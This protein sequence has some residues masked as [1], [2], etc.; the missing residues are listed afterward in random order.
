MDIPRLHKETEIYKQGAIATGISDA[1]QKAESF[2]T[3]VTND[4]I[5]VTPSDAK[6]NAQGQATS[7][8][9]GWH[10]GGALEL[11]RGGVAMF[12]VWLE[13]A[14]AKVRVGSASSGNIVLESDA[15]HMNDG[16]REILSV[17]GESSQ[18]ATRSSIT[19]WHSL[20]DGVG[21]ELGFQ[22]DVNYYDES[23]ITEVASLVAMISPDFANV[24]V[25]VSA[26]S[27]DFYWPGQASPC[28]SGHARVRLAGEVL[29]FIPD[30][31][32]TYHV[33]MRRAASNVNGG[34]TLFSGTYASTYNAPVELDGDLTEVRRLLVEYEDSAGRRGSVTLDL[35]LASTSDTALVGLQ[36]FAA[37][38]TNGIIIRSKTCELAYSSGAW[39]I[40]VAE[41]GSTG[42]YQYGKVTIGTNGAATWSSA[43]EIGITKVVGF[44]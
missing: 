24:H 40:D 36:T 23:D 42:T 34:E 3:E 44:Y 27:R 31:A 11:V 4:G 1:K 25:D 26:N 7:S 28:A 17:V 18:G 2:I 19:S 14:V 32:N 33:P 10:I 22:T 8:T 30:G 6:P 15:I 16:S 39:R 35:A 20:S 21:A 5:W 12:K 38:S 43:E 29:A 9:S 13:N 41:L 37:N